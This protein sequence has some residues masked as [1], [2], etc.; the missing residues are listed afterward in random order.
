MET[1]D[2]KQKQIA[3]IDNNEYQIEISPLPFNQ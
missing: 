3:V 2:N 1:Q